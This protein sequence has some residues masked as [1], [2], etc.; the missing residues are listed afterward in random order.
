MHVQYCSKCR[1]K[2]WHRGD[3]CEWAD[4]HGYRGTKV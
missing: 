4:I 3:V 2:T 1:T